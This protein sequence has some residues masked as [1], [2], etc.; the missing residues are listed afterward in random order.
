MAA[1][2]YIKPDM[3][4]SQEIREGSTAILREG[5]GNANGET[6]RSIGN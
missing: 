2:I 6:K 5:A 1:W 4:L 3:D